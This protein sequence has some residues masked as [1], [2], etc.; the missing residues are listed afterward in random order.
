LKD[1]QTGF[2]FCNGSFGGNAVSALG[3]WEI[4]QID[5]P[6]RYPKCRA[7]GYVVW[8]RESAEKV[9]VRL[10]A[11]FYERPTKKQ[12]YQIELVCQQCGMSQTE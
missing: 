8:K 11:N 6:I 1:P 9:L 5:E 7:D 10:S 12:P 4:P 2:S 3:G